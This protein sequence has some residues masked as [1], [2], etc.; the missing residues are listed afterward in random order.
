MKTPR[1]LIAILALLVLSAPAYSFKP[2]EYGV[3]S[4]ESGTELVCLEPGVAHTNA[5]GD[6]VNLPKLELWSDGTTVVF[7]QPLRAKCWRYDDSKGWQIAAQPD[8]LLSIPGRYLDRELKP[9]RLS[10]PYT[11]YHAGNARTYLVSGIKYEDLVLAED[12]ERELDKLIHAEA[13]DGKKGR[14]LRNRLAALEGLSF[15]ISQQRGALD[16]L[17]WMRPQHV[18]GPLA[19][20]LTAAMYKETGLTPVK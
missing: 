11:W 14:E 2:Y 15:E 18:Y 7:T 16:M 3:T 10:T 19:E 1:L 4:A 8:E 9:L 13:D 5:A 17:S 6:Q 20:K 12:T